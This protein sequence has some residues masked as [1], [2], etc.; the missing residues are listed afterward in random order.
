MNETD[1]ELS[2]AIPAPLANVDREVKGV[3][4]MCSCCKIILALTFPSNLSKES[5]IY[6]FFVE[7]PYIRRT[8]MPDA[9]ENWPRHSLNP[10]LLKTTTT[11]G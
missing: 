8:K 5:M 9:L 1:A 4:E 6:D 3:S 7:F 11:T 10:I 2:Y